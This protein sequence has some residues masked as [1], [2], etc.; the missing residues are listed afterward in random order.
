MSKCNEFGH[1]YE[2]REEDEN[3]TYEICTDCGHKERYCKHDGKLKYI[4]DHR[5]DF[6]Q[7]GSKGFKELY[8]ESVKQK[9]KHN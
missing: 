7:P 2:T 4:E 1:Q 3:Y 8:P 6:I 9:N 5:R